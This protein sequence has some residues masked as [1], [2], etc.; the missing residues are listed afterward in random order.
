MLSPPHQ[1]DKRNNVCNYNTVVIVF[2]SVENMM[3]IPTESL[4]AAIPCA[5]VWKDEKSRYI[6]ATLYGASLVGFD[7]IDQLI[8][9][10]DYDLPKGPS[11]YADHFIS[12]DRD[13]MA[14][15]VSSDHFEVCRYAD[16]LL[17][18]ISKK[19]P[20]YNNEHHIIGTCCMLQQLDTNGSYQKIANHLLNLH[21]H[22]N[23][24]SYKIYSDSKHSILTKREIEVLVYLLYGKTI[25]DIS[26]ILS[27]SVR[28]IESHFNMLKSKFQVN[29]K[30]QLIESAIH[31]G[32]LSIIPSWMF[33]EEFSKLLS[34]Y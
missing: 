1:I 26:K 14:S 32:Y 31:A 17:A 8:G 18:V 20:L 33:K 21:K 19:S 12:Q 28:T 29:S 25:R 10:T 22:K 3:T 24:L 16:G 34:D 9:I 13:V 27:R 2:V 30:S 4:L 11:H 7:S 15:N 6:T 23:N 5:I